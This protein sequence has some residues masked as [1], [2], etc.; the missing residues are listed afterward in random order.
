MKLSN[1]IV[2]K[3]FALAVILAIA[4]LSVSCAAAQK[5]PKPKY[6]FLFIGDGMGFSH[7]AAAEAYL[8][9]T[10]GVGIGNVSLSF[11]QFPAMGMLT[12]YSADSYITCSSAAG[13]ALASGK[14][15]N[16]G[17]L[18]V[19]PQ[20]EIIRSI[21]YDLKDAGFRIGI[22][23]SVSIDHAT[24]AAFFASDTSR[25]NYYAIATQL[26]PSGFEFFA[27]SG[28]VH[29]TGRDKTEDNVYDQLAR[30]RYAV[31][32]T[33]EELARTSTS[34][35]LVMVQEEERDNRSLV[36]MVNRTGDDG[37]TLPD[38]TRT[39]IEWLNNPQGFF[40]MVEGGQ[41]DWAGHDNDAA[42][43]IYEVI[44]FSQAIEIA[45]E[46]YEKHPDETLIVVTADHETG[47]LALG[48]QDTRYELFPQFMQEQKGA[49]LNKD[50]IR[51]LNNRAGFGWTT[52]SHTGGAVPVFAIGAGSEMFRGK[53]DNTEIPKKIKG[54]MMRN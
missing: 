26:A 5:E 15:T 4:T 18:G 3:I 37:W 8:A 31:V 1:I 46:F 6:V 39:G 24:P 49:N 22:A 42:A 21:T 43:V 53:M 50:Q 20:G 35:N 32:R 28:F 33:P 52:G 45:L 17:M 30:A 54:L 7:V 11:T 29:P 16:N 2:K 41:I 47:G 44:D 9:Y 27:G 12:T 36:R 13:T 40:F 34:Q 51:N 25:D 23:S 10:T 19:C 48:Y 14:K 38:F